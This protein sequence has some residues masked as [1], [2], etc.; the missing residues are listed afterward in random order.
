MSLLDLLSRKRNEIVSLWFDEAI[1]T[2]PPETALFLRK[3]R[4][5]F[6]NPVGATIRDGLEGIYDEILRD[7]APER[8]SPFLDNI[9]RIRAVQDFTP[10]RAIS[11]LGDLKRIVR[12]ALP[13]EEMRGAVLDEF[14]ALQG[15]IDDMMFLSFDIFMQC[16]EKI[17]DLKANEVRNMTHRLIERLNRVGEVT[18]DD[19]ERNERVHE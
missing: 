15:R 1:N 19:L 14:L 16:R 9:I 17:Y 8:L 7:A 10:S 5:R 2:Y 6:T 11:F 13:R 12:D 3:Q 4:N 18:R